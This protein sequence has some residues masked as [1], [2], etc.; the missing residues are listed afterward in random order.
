M[1]SKYYVIS[2]L[3]FLTL[4]YTIIFMIISPDSIP[5]HY[6]VLGE[7]DRYGSKYEMIMLPIF[8]LIS[9]IVPMLFAK[10]FKS[11]SDK[12]SEKLSL[13]VGIVLVLMFIALYVLFS[14]MALNSNIEY[15]TDIGKVIIIAIGIFFTVLCNLMPKARLNSLFGIRTSWS[16]A[17]EKTWQKSQRFGGYSGVICGII[18]VI[19]GLV[20]SFEIGIIV[21]IVLITLWAV[22]SSIMSYVFYKKYD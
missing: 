1:K 20:F 6:N 19:S 21:T 11:K 5:M 4:I 18:L 12:S 10:H 14:V 13:N 22:L 17:N 2:A 15:G 9:G 7:I 3:M 8:V 16:I